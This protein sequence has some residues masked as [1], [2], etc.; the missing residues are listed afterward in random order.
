MDP[1]AKPKS[2]DMA[3][4]E[5]DFLGGY[6]AA[7]L[8]EL[9]REGEESGMSERSVDEIFSELFE[10]HFGRKPTLEERSFDPSSHKGP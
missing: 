5:D 10:K 7:E 1:L 4:E 9:L 8:E 3:F 2:A 6:T